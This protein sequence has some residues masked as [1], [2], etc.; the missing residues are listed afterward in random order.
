MREA[1]RIGVRLRTGCT[2]TDRADGYRLTEFDLNGSLSCEAS[3][4]HDPSNAIDPR[5]F[6]SSRANSWANHALVNRMLVSRIV[7]FSSNVKQGASMGVHGGPW[8]PQHNPN[9]DFVY[10]RRYIALWF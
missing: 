1:A 9:L 6:Q 8:G 4:E 3:L 2:A 10:R 7:G 5:D